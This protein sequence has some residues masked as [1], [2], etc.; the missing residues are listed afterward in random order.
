[1]V[2]V[3]R[4]LV[5]QAKSFQ[6]KDYQENGIRSRFLA[7]HQI[8]A[9]EEMVD[10]YQNMF[11]QLKK[12]GLPTICVSYE[13]LRQETE[14]EIDRLVKFLGLTVT[15]EQLKAV[16]DFVQPSSHTWNDETKNQKVT[17]LASDQA[18]F[19]QKCMAEWMRICEDNKRGYGV[20]DATHSALL[21]R[22]LNGKPALPKPP[23]RSFSYPNYSLG[24]GLP[25][26]IIE[27]GEYDE[28]VCIDQC[29]E[30]RWVDKDKGLLIHIPTC[31]VYRHWIET[32]ERNSVEIQDG[33]LVPSK[34]EAKMLQKMDILTYPEAFFPS[35]KASTMM[36]EFKEKLE[37]ESDVICN[38]PNNDLAAS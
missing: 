37:K 26:E 1:L 17:S 6:S 19:A 4:D 18:F 27:L 35:P 5:K 2:F 33:V 34:Y 8:A 28:K 11:D 24:E 12:F 21:Y 9:M 29:S 25:T 13:A 31:D 22:L 23:P 36:Q 16:Q 20:P 10:N 3:S 7:R 30:Y 15:Q 38:E 32:K 14:I